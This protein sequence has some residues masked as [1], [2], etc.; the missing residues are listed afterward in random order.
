MASQNVTAV[1]S[2][3]VKIGQHINKDRNKSWSPCYIREI[4]GIVIFRMD[5]KLKIK[6]LKHKCGAHYRYNQSLIS[7]VALKNKEDLVFWFEHPEQMSIKEM[8]LQAV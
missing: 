1:V 2:Q 3:G 5:T 4:K 8:V 7:F 6:M